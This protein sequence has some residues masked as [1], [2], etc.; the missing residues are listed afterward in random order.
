MIANLDGTRE[1]VLFEERSPFMFFDNSDFESYPMHWHTPIEIV[2]PTEQTYDVDVSGLPF[3][4]RK[5]D[6]LIIGPC[7]LHEFHACKGKRYIFQADM[8]FLSVFHEFD[9]ILSVLNSA[10][11]I[12]PEAYSC[13]SEIVQLLHKINIEYHSHHQMKDAQICSYFLQLMVSVSRAHTSMPNKFKDIKPTKQREYQDK[14]MSVCKYI[15]D[16]CTEDL[17][18]EQVAGLAGFSKYHFSR[19]FKEFTNVSF[20]KYLNMHRISY[21]EKLLMD[22]LVNVTEAAVRSGFNSI[23]AFMRMFKIVKGCT[24]TEFRNM[25]EFHKSE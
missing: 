1:T 11:V 19:L 17:S 3:R 8:N 23:S 25:L 14:F 9:S 13:H 24:P 10:L 16:H 5:N 20:Y 18:L 12:T 6:I 7:V 2:M 22:P 21:A 15:N 4:L